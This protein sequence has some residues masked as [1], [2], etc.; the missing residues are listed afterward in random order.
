MGGFDKALGDILQSSSFNSHSKKTT[1]LP[2]S[3]TKQKQ[4]QK[5]P[6]QIFP[7]VKV[8]NFYSDPYKVNYTTLGQ[9]FDSFFKNTKHRRFNVIISTTYTFLAELIVSINLIGTECQFQSSFPLIS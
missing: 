9:I 2:Q 4:N 1:P 7:H 6:F 8:W 5:T 3:K